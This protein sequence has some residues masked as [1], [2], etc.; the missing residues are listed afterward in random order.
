MLEEALNLSEEARCS[1]C[2]A[3]CFD[4]SMLNLT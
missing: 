2:M 4:G 1:R 3:G